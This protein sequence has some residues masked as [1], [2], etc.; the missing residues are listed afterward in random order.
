M[1]INQFLIRL[2]YMMIIIFGGVFTIRYFRMNELLLDQ[3]I[4]VFIGAILLIVS[5][6]WRRKY[7]L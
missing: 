1:K 4:G 2:S 6:L 5:L 7:M 3:L